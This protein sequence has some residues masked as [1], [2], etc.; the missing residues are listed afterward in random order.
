MEERRTIKKPH[1]AVRFLLQLLSFLLCIAMLCAA[2]ATALVADVRTVTSQDGIKDLVMTTLDGETSTGTLKEDLVEDLMEALIQ[3]EGKTT[4]IAEEKIRILVEESTLVEFFVE[5]AAGYLSDFFYGENKTS[6]TPEELVQLVKENKKV[7]EQCLGFELSDAVMDAVAEAAGKVDFDSKMRQIMT[8]SLG[9]TEQSEENTWMANLRKLISEKTIYGLLG[10]CA[11]I[12]VL[13][14]LGNYYNIPGGLGWISAGLIL[15]GTV[16]SL[17]IFLA[18]NDPAKMAELLGLAAEGKDVFL[19]LVS[20]VA[21]V[22]Y[23]VLGIGVAVA[24]A[25]IVW[26]IVRASRNK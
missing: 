18:L 4:N 5:K 25:S 22:H 21:P 20:S 1:G 6:I 11:A 13:L 26:R 10:L 15:A 23:T 14:L 12:A 9:E 7:L 16:L 8:D 19:G 3:E 2:T 17:P 24:V